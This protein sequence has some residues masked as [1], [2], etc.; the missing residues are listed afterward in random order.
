MKIAFWSPI[1]GRVGV[2]TNMTCIAAMTSIAGAGKTM[3][4]ENHYGLHNIGDIIL[5]P[6]QINEIRE[7]SRYYYKYG[8][9]YVLKQLYTGEN[10]ADVIRQTAIPLLY[11]SMYYLPQSYIVNREVF[12]Y[13]FNLVREK[14]FHCLEETSDF[15]F[16]DTETNQN[17]SSNS[18]LSEAD[19]IVV[20]LPQDPQIM[21]N[22]FDHYTSIR[23][24]GV[25]LIGEYQKEYAWNLRRI[26][27]RYHI[28]RDRIGV[29]PYNMELE[30]SLRQGRLLQFLNRNYYQA[31]GRENDYFI[32]QTKKASMMVRQ[33]LLQIRRERA[34]E[35][36]V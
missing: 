25:F 4:L 34:K 23:E 12:N 1:R 8:I 13:E 18:I 10:G 24:K 14:L 3:L 32:R 35:D 5:A 21:D 15:I 6:E 20:N 33:N 27:Y 36:L 26:C 28:S 17:L 7:Q 31:S 29:I 2:T 11:T 19:L 22:F 16:I 30:E 9:E